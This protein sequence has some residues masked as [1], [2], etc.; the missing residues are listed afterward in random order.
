MQGALPIRKPTLFA[1]TSPGPSEVSA[2]PSFVWVWRDESKCIVNDDASSP[3]MCPIPE[4]RFVLGGQFK[5]RCK[6]A[7]CLVAI[8]GEQKGEKIKHGHLVRRR[9]APDV[10]WC[11]L[12]LAAIRGRKCIIAIHL[13]VLNRS[14]ASA[15]KPWRSMS[16]PVAGT[17][18]S[19]GSPQ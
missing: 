4:S 10:T 2:P 11:K 3:G 9:P 18:L 13:R 14:F 1:V 16:S 6:T 15:A 8:C 5:A 17:E 19:G 7:L 12:C